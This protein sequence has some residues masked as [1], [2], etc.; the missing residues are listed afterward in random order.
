[1]NVLILVEKSNQGNRGKF[2]ENKKHNKIGRFKSS[3]LYFYNKWK[4]TT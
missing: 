2:P 3:T 1:M 4:V